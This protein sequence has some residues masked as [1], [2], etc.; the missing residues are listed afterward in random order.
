M[1]GYFGKSSLFC[2]L[3]GL[4][5]GGAAAL[6][7][8][9]INLGAI[10]DNDPAGRDVT[11]AVSGATSPLADV[12]VSITLAHTFVGD[13]E[14]ELVSPG[15]VARRVIFARTGRNATGGNGGNDLGDTYVFSDRGRDWWAAVAAIT[16]VVPGGEFRAS[17]TATTLTPLKTGGCTV[18][19][20][21]AFATL[22]PV[23]INGTWTLHIAD[24]AAA[25]TGAISAARLRLI[26]T[27]DAIFASGFE[28]PGR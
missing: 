18:P 12:R 16:G 7:F 23:D 9:G 10:P 11:F 28:S 3:L 25:D 21:F 15:G 8:S 19:I 26:P 2:A 20:T 27:N 24:R 22:A 5:S 17:T 1:G 4:Y 6:E 14:V 13:L